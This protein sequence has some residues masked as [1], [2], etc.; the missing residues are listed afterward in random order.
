MQ[1][2]WA[3]CVQRLYFIWKLDAKVW[4]PQFISNI[5]CQAAWHISDIT[6]GGCQESYSPRFYC[7][8]SSHRVTENIQTW[9]SVK[10]WCF[11]PEEKNHWQSRVLFDTFKWALHNASVGIRWIFFWKWGLGRPLRLCSKHTCVAY[12]ACM[13]LKQP[14][15]KI[16]S[17]GLTVIW[18]NLMCWM[19]MILSLF[20]TQRS[21]TW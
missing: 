10:P 4:L 7:G 5:R 21:W 19:A 14:K 8:Q 11:N 15:G 2:H 3:L 9:Q 12:W 20:H 18:V 1:N 17:M 16:F 6:L 13:L